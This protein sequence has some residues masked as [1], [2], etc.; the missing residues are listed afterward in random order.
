MIDTSAMVKKGCKGDATV[1]Q[2]TIMASV[3]LILDR[4]YKAIREKV[5]QKGPRFQGIFDWAYNYRLEA[6]RQGEEAPIMD[7]LIFRK[8]KAAL[9]GK[10][11]AVFTG[12]AP[13]APECHNFIRVCLGAKVLQGYGLTETTACATIMEVD[14]DIS[15]GLVGPPNQGMQIKLV[16]WE[17]GNYRVTDKPRPRGEIIIGGSSVADG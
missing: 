13:L 1:L 5:G 17:E 2:P 8:M 9:G 14:D 3:P 12:G 4:I 15:V 7:F 6:L 16:N 11:M 10:V